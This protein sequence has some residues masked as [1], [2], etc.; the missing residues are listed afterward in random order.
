M[1]DEEKIFTHSEE[2]IEII[3]QKLKDARR[4]VPT[5]ID[6]GA[7]EVIYVPIDDGELKIY[8]HTPDNSETKRPI[9]F[10]PG[11]VAAP[12]T[13][14]DFHIPHHGFAEY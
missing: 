12:S 11:F 4:D 8:H 5:F 7:A 14:V 1:L 6:E 3:N 9:I 13:W 2:E 10:V